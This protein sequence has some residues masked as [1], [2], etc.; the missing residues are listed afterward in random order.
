MIRGY[1]LISLGVG[2]Q[3]SALYYMSSMGILPRINMAIFADT[4]GEKSKTLEYL[5]YL[6]KWKKDNNGI[7]I[8]VANFINLENDLLRED[9]GRFSSIPAFTLNEDGEKGMLRRQC[10]GE[11]KIAQ[12]NKKYRELMKLGNKYFPK[13]EVWIG[14]TQEEKD[15]MAIPLEQWK[16]NVYPFCGYKIYHD[17]HFELFPGFESTRTSILSWYKEN[18]LPIPEKSSCK[19]CPFHGYNSWKRL[20]EISPSD[21]EDACKVD[22]KIRHSSMKGVKN[23]IYLHESL[24]PLREVK[25]NT[26]T[27]GF[28][29]DH[30]NCSDNCGI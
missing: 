9:E 25:F 11:Y 7:P 28:F 21:F 24:K 26:R 30:G 5:Q 16:I 17:G 10:T 12:I 19:F 4:G 13:T 22:D 20:K 6:Q 27:I 3:S 18:N 15:R 14:I 2:V 1:S 8:H 29:D 23:P